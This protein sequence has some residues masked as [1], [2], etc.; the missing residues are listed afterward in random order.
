[1]VISG[2]SVVEVVESVVEGAR[3][4]EEKLGFGPG[5]VWVGV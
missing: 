2:T 4:V 5:V 3:V 1:M